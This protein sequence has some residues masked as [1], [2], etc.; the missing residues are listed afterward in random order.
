MDLESKHNQAIR[1][2]IGHRLRSLLT[3]E[4]TKVTP[5]LRQLALRLDQQYLAREASPP[6]APEIEMPDDPV[7]SNVDPLTAWLNRLRVFRRR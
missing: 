2:E 3:R 7:T 1:E 5:Q 6:I 4:Q